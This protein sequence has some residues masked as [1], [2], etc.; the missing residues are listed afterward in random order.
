MKWS[1]IKLI[2]RRELRDQLRD[3]RTLFMIAVLPVLLYPLL[4]MTF[5]QVAQ[6]LEE[7]PTKIWVIGAEQ[8]PETPLLIET[9][10]SQLASE[11]RSFVA[12]YFPGDATS[13]E[14]ASDLLPI[15]IESSSLANPAEEA[16]SRI[17]DGQYDAVVI[18]PEGFSDR[19]DQYNNADDY[20]SAE[21]VPR[22]LILFDAGKDRSRIAYD[23]VSAVLEAW[24]Q[25]VVDQ[26]LRDH[27]VPLSATIPFEVETTNL[28]TSKGGGGAVWS[29]ILPFVLLVWALTGA[30]YPAIDLCAGEK[31]RGTLETLLCSPARRSEIVVGKLITVMIFSIAT[32]VLNLASL[33]LTA[34]LSVNQLS[35]ISPHV[36]QLGT[37]SPAS[38]GWLLVALL[39]LSALFSALSIALAAMAR[40]TKEGQY[41]LMPLLLITMPLMMLPILPAVELDLGKSLIPVTGVMLL[42]RSLLE[43]EYLTAL[44]FCL[45]VILVTGACCWFAIR[46]A[47]DQFNDES[48]L[49][50][51]GERF[52][53]SAW[54]V[55]LIRDRGATPS[56]AEA[57]LCGA[58]LLMIRFFASLSASQGDSWQFLLKSTLI[59]QVALVATPVLL[60]TIFLTRDPRKTLVLK[61]PRLLTLPAVVL[62]V[63]CVH[64][65]AMSLSQLISWLYPID[66]NVTASFESLTTVMREAPIG[67]LLLTFA[68]LPAICEELAFRGFILSGLRHIGHKWRA[69]LISSFF[70]GI[71]HGILQQSIN[72]FAL[73]MILGFI[74]IQTGSL[75]PCIL[76]HMTHNS[77]VLLAGRYI[78]P[79]HVDKYWFLKKVDDGFIYSWQVVALGGMGTI[80]LLFWF[81]RLPYQATEEEQLQQSLDHQQ[82][83]P[84]SHAATLSE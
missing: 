51:E 60:M 63:I 14:R 28:A 43:G 13:R 50:R 39:P 9:A 34:V 6:F 83:L 76:F 84:P 55:H 81:R 24:R 18:F 10:P 32:A 71:I 42:L 7:H 72:A 48:V 56:F 52:D 77:L 79:E 19:F 33:M 68:L 25:R 31:E 15:I 53:L 75:L 38:I 20:S 23:R 22:P 54:F 46:W 66:S 5:M 69:I 30:F 11:E 62:L 64:P 78:Q 35:S 40:S 67:W 17:A 36:A 57:V 16:Q 29:K 21:D 27:Q 82:I 65:V 44:Q 12:K 80:I 4:G 26:N 37:P 74:V 47:V 59:V 73:G 58:L 70:F 61:M 49:F 8:L 45:P 3:R 41:Y 2:F 1:H